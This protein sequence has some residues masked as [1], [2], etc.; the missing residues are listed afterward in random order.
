[1]IKNILNK[2]LP[3]SI[4][5]IVRDT[6]NKIPIF[7]AYYYDYKRYY[8]FSISRRRNEKT[9]LI[10]EIIRDYHVI[11]KGLTMPE[12][13]LGFGMERLLKLCSL[14]NFFVSNFGNKEPQ[15]IHAISV[16]NEYKLFHLHNKYDLDETVLNE[17]KLVNLNLET[18]SPAEQKNVSRA[19]YFNNIN[20]SFELF[21]NSRSSIRNFTSEDIPIDKIN[22]VFNLVRNT[23]S[24]CNRQSWRTYVVTNSTMIK[25]IL[26]LQGGNRGFGH[27]TNKLIVVTSD[28]AVFFNDL[29]RNQAFID[30]GMYAM[31]VLYGLHHKEIAACILNCSHT[32]NKDQE[33]RKLIPIKNSEVFIAMIACGIPPENFSIAVSK[34]YEIENTVEVID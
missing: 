8:N 13:R 16:L 15:L 6:K 12:T 29:E 25:E 24:A 31:N 5:L 9:K 23:P 26:K 2:I 11:E 17:L 4:F 3:Q 1:M 10:S 32:P 7:F 34:R 19:E 14:C 28:T 30:G 18:S 20:S 22:A 33:M 27:L 21:S